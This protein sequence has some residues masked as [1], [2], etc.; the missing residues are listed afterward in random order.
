MYPAKRVYGFVKALLRDEC[1]ASFDDCYLNHL[2]ECLGTEHVFLNT[3]MLCDGRNRSLLDC[4]SALFT[5]GTYG[6]PTVVCCAEHINSL[7]AQGGSLPAK[8]ILRMALH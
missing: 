3:H 8:S 4:F 1:G 2:E 5:V 7:N 6:I